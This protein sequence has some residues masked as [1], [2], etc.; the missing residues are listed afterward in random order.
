MPSRKRS[1]GGDVDPVTRV[2]IVTLGCARNEVDSE[3][4]AHRLQADGLVL[5]DD[6][7]QADAVLVNTCGFVE[8]AKKD[9]IDTL[10]EVSTPIHP[11]AA[12]GQSGPKVIAVGCLAE[13][14]GRD[15]AESLPEAAAVLSFDDYPEITQRV[16]AVL[17]GATLTAHAPSDRRR[18]RTG[19]SQAAPPGVG[20][21]APARP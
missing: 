20:S 15:L 16:R 18:R 8:A 9:S 6:P 21:D 5:V 3:E 14:Y 12:S 1:A 17:S 19:G 13:R 2:A 7:D 10:L 11:T 4:L